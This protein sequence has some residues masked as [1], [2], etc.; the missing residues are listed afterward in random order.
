MVELT[1]KNIR[2][3]KKILGTDER[4]RIARSEKRALKSQWGFGVCVTG[5]LCVWQAVFAC[6]GSKY[7]FAK[8]HLYNKLRYGGNPPNI[9]GKVQASKEL[10]CVDFVQFKVYRVRSHPFIRRWCLLLHQD[11]RSRHAPLSRSTRKVFCLPLRK[12]SKNS[13]QFTVLL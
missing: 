12:L 5:G 10:V 9:N 1:P 11:D 13:V 7:S 4:Q 2:L 3:R 6:Y 8:F